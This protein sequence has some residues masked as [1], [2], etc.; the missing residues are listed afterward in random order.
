MFV[1]HTHV[2]IAFFG[3]DEIRYTTE[4]PFTL[5]NG[6]PVIINTGAVG[7]P[8]DNDPRACYC[9]YDTQTRTAEWRRVE[10]DIARTIGKIVL[11]GL[12]EAL[13]TRL[14]LGK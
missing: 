12:P 9:V 5:T 1:G 4:A 3:G 8:R 14:S 11:A 7:Q 6:A 13:G 2:P 10:Y